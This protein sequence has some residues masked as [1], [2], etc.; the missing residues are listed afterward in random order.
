VR[1]ALLRGLTHALS[2]RVMAIATLSDLAGDAG[3]AVTTRS[4]LASEAGRLD[5]LLQQFRLLSPPPPGPPEPLN[6]ADVLSP[7]VELAARHPDVAGTPSDIRV[8]VGVQ[9]A[10]VDTGHVGRI[11]PALVIAAMR[12]ARRVRAT[13][14][15]VDVL[16]DA[17]W[18]VIRATAG[19]AG[20]TGAQSNEAAA[21]APAIGI[22]ETARGACY[23][24][25]MPTLAAARRRERGAS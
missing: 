20:P 3:A 19:D 9:P 4:V 15:Q 13:R 7:L 10:F 25:L 23:E 24:L 17:R 14:V 22:A 21:G 1:D 12:V 5:A 11:V 2:N 6:V 8:A 18:V 16:G